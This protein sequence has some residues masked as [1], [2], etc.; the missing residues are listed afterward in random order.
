M[1]VRLESKAW[2][3]WPR[4]TGDKQHESHIPCLLSITAKHWVRVSPRPGVDSAFMPLRIKPYSEDVHDSQG[5]PLHCLESWQSISTSSLP[6]STQLPKVWSTP[7]LFISSSLPPDPCASGLHSGPLTHH[8]LTLCTHWSECPE[9]SSSPTA[10]LG[11]MHFQVLW[12]RQEAFP[13]PWSRF[14]FS[15]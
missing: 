5:Q 4:M 2:C 12:N 10:N 13:G 1:S 6:Q 7:G 8:L 15:V 3:C 14:S 9:C 11:P